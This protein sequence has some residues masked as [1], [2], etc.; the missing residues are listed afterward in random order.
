MKPQEKIKYLLG[1][2]NENENKIAEDWLKEIE[3]ISKINTD[4]RWKN[5]KNK[6]EKP[7]L[8]SNYFTYFARIAAV[9]VVAFAVWQIFQYNT[10]QD[11]SINNS[12]I[13]VSKISDTVINLPDKSQIT[14][15]K[16][17]VVAYNKVNFNKKNREIELK[18]GEIFCNIA[19]NKQKPFI[20][21]TK[22]SQTKVLGTKF[23][24]KIDKNNVSVALLEGKVEFQTN[25]N[26]KY[27]LLP[28]DKIIL[29][30]NSSEINKLHNSINEFAWINKDL[31]F[32]NEKLLDIAKDLESCYNI[33]T[34]FENE[35][36]KHLKLS[37][38]F[39]GKSLEQVVNIIN[40]S[41]NIESSP[42]I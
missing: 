10:K 23:I 1:E 41:L 14:L 6:I 11:E 21:K 31:K 33:K 36:I 32:E 18:R 17:S 42:T 34:S 8:K 28:N 26:K 24:V 9:V 7:R 40:S 29:T 4:D 20:V 22:K 2:A 39:K 27:T 38:N 3:N 37:A 19:K 35:K 5:L 12:T 13:L 15:K 25:Q 30:L 16:N